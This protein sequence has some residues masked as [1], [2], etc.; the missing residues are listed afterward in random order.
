MRHA[1][2]DLVALLPPDLRERPDVR[3]LASYGCLT[4]MHVV[5]LLAPRMSNEDH[6]KDIDFT[7]PGISKRWESGLRDARLALAQKPWQAD[8]D[9]REGFYLHEMQRDAT[10]PAHMSVRHDP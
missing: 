8:V 3:D 5:R 7:R 6:T 10:D 4:R 2:A 1:I 9:P